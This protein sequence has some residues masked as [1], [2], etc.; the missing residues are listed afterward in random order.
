MAETT[1]IL[2]ET[3]PPSIDEARS[4]VGF[5]LDDTAGTEVGTVRGLFIDSDGGAPAW[6]VIAVERRGLLR[7]GAVLVAVPARDCAGGAGR[8]WTAHDRRALQSA[9]VVDPDRPLLREHEITIC[10]H[11]EIGPGVGRAAEVV[12]RPE[13]AVTAE[14]GRA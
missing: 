1:E 3:G 4:W 14:P 6:L 5:V 10:A 7:R 8:V 13:A 11:Y 9:P 2:P 12:N